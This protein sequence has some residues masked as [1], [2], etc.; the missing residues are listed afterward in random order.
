MSEFDPTLKVK[1]C[2]NCKMF[3]A[4]NCL[5]GEDVPGGTRSH[6]ALSVLSQGALEI[7]SVIGQPPLLVRDLFSLGKGLLPAYAKTEG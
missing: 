5:N 6:E 3:D 4:T 1:T 7:S 2:F